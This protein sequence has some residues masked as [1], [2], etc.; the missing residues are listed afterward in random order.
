MTMF[1]EETT[2]LFAI[3]M[4]SVIFN[5]LVLVIVA[6]AQKTRVFFAI[7]SHMFFTIKIDTVVQSIFSIVCL[8]L[9]ENYV[10]LQ[11][12]RYVAI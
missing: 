2:K 5:S 6:A 11:A 1:G 12:I 8:S 9:L 7:K 4:D 3:L 10:L